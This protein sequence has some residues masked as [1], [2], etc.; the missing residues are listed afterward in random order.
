MYL[1]VFYHA[2]TNLEKTFAAVGIYETE[3][4]S[5]NELGT[6]RGQLLGQPIINFGKAYAT[7]NGNAERRLNGG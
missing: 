6:I 2:S 4:M 7:L 1:L 5:G 3:G